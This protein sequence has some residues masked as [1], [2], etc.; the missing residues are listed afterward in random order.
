MFIHLNFN[1][2]GP[3][4]DKNGT[5]GSALGPDWVSGMKASGSA[6]VSIKFYLSNWTVSM[7]NFWTKTRFRKTSM[8]SIGAKLRK[9]LTGRNFYLLNLPYLIRK[10]L[11][12]HQSRQLGPFMS[13]WPMAGFLVAILWSVQPVLNRMSTCNLILISKY[14]SNNM[15]C[16]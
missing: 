1:G 5:K 3:E 13:S 4:C 6:T 12:H 7:R 2:I 8:F 9:F 16:L 10:T 15:I 11:K 14:R